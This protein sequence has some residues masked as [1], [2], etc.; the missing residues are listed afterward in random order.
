MAAPRCG[1]S[2]RSTGS[3][4][5]P[6]RAQRGPQDRANAKAF[7]SPSP[8]GLKLP[9]LYRAKKNKPANSRFF[10]GW[11]SHVALRAPRFDGFA[12][13]TRARGARSAG[14]SKRPSVCEPIPVGTQTFL[15]TRFR[16]VAQLSLPIQPRTRLSSTVSFRFSVWRTPTDVHIESSRAKPPGARPLA[17]TPATVARPPALPR[18]SCPHGRASSAQSSR[19]L[20]SPRR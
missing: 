14:P 7:A 11:R 19:R 3:P 4:R 9:A 15:L 5:E 10:F 16:P 1:E 18:G 17:Q 2:P 6:G 13:R 8:W 12:P 20:R